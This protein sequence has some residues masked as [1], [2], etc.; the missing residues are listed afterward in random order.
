M[1]CL[2]ENT[3]NQLYVGFSTY[4]YVVQ[5]FN[6]IRLHCWWR[7]PSRCIKD[8]NTLGQTVFNLCPKATIIN[9]ESTTEAEPGGAVVIPAINYNDV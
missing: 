2:L 4:S 7:Q 5:Y 3:T 1:F 6:P 8:K 9:P